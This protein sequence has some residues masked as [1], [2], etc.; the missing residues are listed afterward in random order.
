MWYP[1][2]S[3]TVLRARTLCRAPFGKIMSGG[4]DSTRFKN[5]AVLRVRA[6]HRRGRKPD[7]YTTALIDTGSRMTTLSLKEF[8]GT[9]NLEIT[10]TAS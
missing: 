1:L 8:K 4:I 6:K 5:E 2:D 9:G 7:D 3:S 10:S